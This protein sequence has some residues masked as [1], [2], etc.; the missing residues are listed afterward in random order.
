MA[1]L[2]LK[3][4]KHPS[5]FALSFTALTTGLRRFSTYHDVLENVICTIKNDANSCTI[6]LLL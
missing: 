4:F 2:S 3:A 1:G 5:F 6:P